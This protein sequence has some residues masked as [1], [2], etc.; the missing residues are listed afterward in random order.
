MPQLDE[1]GNEQQ[2]PTP[3]TIHLAQRQLKKDAT[4]K[5][6]GKYLYALS[7]VELSRGAVIH[8]LLQFA[9]HFKDEKAEQFL[10]SIRVEE[11]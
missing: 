4:Q 6:D 9:E 10:F 7:E 8:S 3:T 2:N 1:Y 5:V 11:K